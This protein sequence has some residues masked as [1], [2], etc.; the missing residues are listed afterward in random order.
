MVLRDACLANEHSN[1][2]EID[3][4]T[5]TF[6]KID[7]G[8]DEPVMKHTAAEDQSSRSQ[9]TGTDDGITL[10]WFSNLSEGSVNPVGVRD[11]LSPSR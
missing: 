10:H 11:A 5:N 1:G 8:E 2:S 3:S 4:A 9:P 7:K 6:V